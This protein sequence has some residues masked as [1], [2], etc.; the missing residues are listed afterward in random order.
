MTREN[1]EQR[2]DLYEGAHAET[3]GVDEDAHVFKQGKVVS[4]K[5][6]ETCNGCGENNAGRR[7][8]TNCGTAKPSSG[9]KPEFFKPRA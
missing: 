8:C 3:N 5:T 1:H 6:E 4:P 2:T 7:F 9:L